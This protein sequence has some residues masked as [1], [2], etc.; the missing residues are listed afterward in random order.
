MTTKHYCATAALLACCLGCQVLQRHRDPWRQ[1]GQVPINLVPLL[2]NDGISSAARPA[3]G[4]FDCPDHPA[5]IPGS[6]YPAEHLP[7]GGQPFSP[8]GHENLR[9][10]FPNVRDQDHNNVICAGQKIDV[11]AARYVALWLL[12]AAENGEHE[13]TLRLNYEDGRVE[14]PLKFPDWCAEGGPD[15]VVAAACPH[16]YSWQEHSREMTKEDIACRVFA[17]RLPVEAPRVLESFNLPYNTRMHVFAV[18]LEARSWSDALQTQVADCVAFYARPVEKQEERT[19]SLRQTQR[20][21][22]KRL[23]GTREEIGL[24]GA[25]RRELGWLATQL[26]YCAHLLP[27]GKRQPLPWQA[28]SIRKMHNLIQR[29]LGAIRKGHNPF[30]KRKGVILK[31]YVSEIDG[32]PQPY[33]I[34]IPP[35]YDGQAP[36][37]LVLHMHGHGWYRPFQGHP[38]PRIPEAIVV[39]PH[40]RGSMDYLFV[41]EADAMR[42][43][44]EARRDYQIDENRICAM[45]HSMGGTGSWHLAVRHPD[46]FAAIAPNASNADHGIWQR[47]WWWTHDWQPPFDKLCAFV[48][49][50]CDSTTYADNLLNTPA[51]TI[52][53]S[54]DRVCPVGH[55]R[56][57]AVRLLNLGHPAIYKELPGVGHGGFPGEVR[58]AQREWLFQQVRD[59]ARGLARHH[60]HPPRETP[61]MGQEEQP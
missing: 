31:S 37:P 18:S 22:R 3:D 5:N 42:T 47:E 13:G 21:L 49:R 39:S 61:L 44:E 11:P 58:K 41:G 2:D 36:V 59:P 8:P 52:H 30:A 28:R 26:D 24:D 43:I 15:V 23:A 7:P 12:G 56:R 53:G 60:R 6:T 40:G 16:R 38:A 34:S 55:A 27:R 25:F 19:A 50:A 29:D 51:Y 57:M 54:D 32:Q 14:V 10:L 45:G 48:E 33:S 46:V 20:A 4:N 17:V 35:T 9:F 1:A